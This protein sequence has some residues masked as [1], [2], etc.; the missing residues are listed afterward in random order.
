MSGSSLTTGAGM[1]WGPSATENP[2]PPTL[3][4]NPA[5]VNTPG[6]QQQ[7]QAVQTN[8][9]AQQGAANNSAL[10]ALQRAGVA[11]GSEASN[12]LGNIAGQTAQ[13]T[14]QGLSG[15]QS[16]Q[17]QE[18]EG[19]LNSLNQAANQQYATSAQNNLGNQELRQQLL[20]GAG[21]ALTTL[22]SAAALAG[23]F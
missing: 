18:Q 12:A 11:G 17:F 7:I 2:A 5:S 10:A 15:L 22:G 3:L 19:L 13:G 16:Q 23:L 4:T 6:M 20:G 14:A 21:S 8:A 9:G 1:P